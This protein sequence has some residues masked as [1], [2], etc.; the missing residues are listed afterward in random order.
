MSRTARAFDGVGGY[1]GEGGCMINIAVGRGCVT[2]T[3]TP[4]PPL[5]V[6]IAIN[7]P[8]RPR[9]L[10]WPPQNQVFSLFSLG[11]LFVLPIRYG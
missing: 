11:R 6:L 10:M 5:A 2:P 1:I 7:H 3:P 8:L 9:P 4:V